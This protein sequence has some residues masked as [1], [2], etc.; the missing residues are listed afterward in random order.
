MKRAVAAIGACAGLLSVAAV[1]VS[2]PAATAESPTRTKT[3]TVTSTTTTTKT[4]TTTV[5][6]TVTRTR[7]AASVVIEG[8]RTTPDGPVVAQRPN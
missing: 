4:S 7:A 5:T 3:V 6:A 8:E 1:L 2:T